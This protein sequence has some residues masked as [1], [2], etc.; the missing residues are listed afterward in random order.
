LFPKQK[1][2]FFTYVADLK[3]ALEEN[4]MRICVQRM[5]SRA[6]IHRPLGLPRY[7]QIIAAPLAVGPR[8]PR[9]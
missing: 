1:I 4:G 5:A 2:L 7:L 8:S 6:A 3:R 9:E